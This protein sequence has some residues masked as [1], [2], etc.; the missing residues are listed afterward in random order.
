V[1]GIV[2]GGERVAWAVFLGGASAELAE[3]PSMAHHAIDIH[4]HIVPADFPP[5][6]GNSGGLRWPQMQPAPTC[7]H[8]NVIIDG[9]VF[10]TLT[11]ECRDVNRR[12]G[13]MMAAGIERQVL[14][15]M[16]G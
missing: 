10:R 3:E 4:T 13:A 2:I 6:A 8:R 7:G 9:D 12:L 14:S 5:Y 16:R 11:D 1:D 15:P